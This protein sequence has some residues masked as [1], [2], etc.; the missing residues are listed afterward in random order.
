M[1]KFWN[2]F[3]GLAVLVLATGCVSNDID[4]QPGDDTE[5]TEANPFDFST[6]S[7]VNLT[8]NYAACNPVGPVFF[9]VYSEYPYEDDSP[10]AGIDANIKPI[11]EDYTDASGKFS[12]TV[13]LPAYAKDLYVVTGNFFI[14]DNLM[15]TT[16]NN[17]QASAVASG[18]ESRAASRAMRSSTTGT[19]TND[20]SKL[21]QLTNKVDFRTGDDTGVQICKE[22]YTPLG[23]WDSESGRPNYLLDKND[24]QNAQFIFTDEEME[25]LQETIANALVANQP[26]REEY[27]MQADLTLEETS[28]VTVTMIGS[29]TCWNSSLGYYYYQG[30]APTNLMDVNVIMLFPNTQDGKSSFLKT[31]KLDQYNGNIGMERGDVVKLMYYPN[32]GN[33]GDLSGATSTFPA[34]TKIGFVIK[35]NAWGMQKTDPVTGKKYYNGYTGGV[36]N[37]EVARQYNVWGCSTDGLSY[38]PPA[39]ECQEQ[40]KY[41]DGS[42]KLVNSNR[43]SRTA[44]FAYQNESGQ[45]YA[46]VSFED[47]CN[48]LDYDDVILALK[49]VS[50]FATLPTITDKTSV[51]TGVYAFEDLWPKAGD[52]DLNDAVIDFKHERTFSKYGSTYKISKETF[53]LT[54]YQNYVELRSGLAMAIN[55]KTTPSSIVMK[56]LSKNAEEPEETTFPYEGYG[57]CYLLAEDIQAELNTTYIMELYYNNG[58][59]QAATAKPFLYRL[60]EEGKS[61]RWE[62]HI[63]FEAPTSKM[64]TSLFGTADDLSVPAEDKYYVRSGDYPFAFFLSGVTV[65][66]FKNTLLN[67]DYESTKINVL[68]PKF[69]EWS[70]SKGEKSADWYLYPAVQ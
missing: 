22:W 48:D 24:P 31:R 58:A 45:Q 67:K 5:E 2:L 50:V 63:P 44:K 26:C 47:A 40:T 43:D 35:S 52:Y 21:Y 66:N 9:S 64:D 14:S 30:D 37:A 38:C 3:V 23:T 20:V 27:R 60:P 62:V 12:E 17:G 69:L 6:V 32:I 65:E 4:Y 1:K 36:K 33:G 53:Y 10:E 49:P 25:G 55:T 13:E 46:I 15:T 59:S 11:Y 41:D 16:V 51:T 42:M 68:Y 7:S 29:N 34:G 54:T 70:K 57:K 61:K 28:E 18:D 19:A 56:K 39:A 8:V